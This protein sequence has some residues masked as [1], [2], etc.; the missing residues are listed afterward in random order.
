VFDA[1]SPRLVVTDS[2]GRRLI[3]VEKA[4]VTLGRRSDNDVR[5][6][7]AGVSRRHAEIHVGPDGCRIQDCSSRFGTFVNGERRAD[8]VLTHGDRIRLGQSADTDI[9]FFV[10]DADDL[11]SQAKSAV[12]AASE[13]RNLAA[14]L[15]G[16]RALGSGRVL[17]DVLTL[18]LDAA[19][20]VTGAERAFI[21][22]AQA[23][24]R[25]EFMR[26]RGRGRVTLSGQTFATSR[27][28]PDTVFATG[29]P[30]IVEDLLDTGL[31]AAHAGTVAIGIRHVLCT[32]LRLVR[33]VERVDDRTED[34]RI[35]VL[36]LDSRERGALGAASTRS[37][38]ETL[39]T[40]AAIAIENARLYREALERSKLEQELQ[41]A[42]AIQQAL[43]PNGDVTGGFFTIA[44]TSMPCRAIGGDFFDYLDRPGGPFGFMLGDV[45]GKG[46]PAALLAA[47]VLGMFSAEAG[48]HT[49]PGALMTRLNSGLL[50]RH[51]EA[52]FVTAFYGVLAPDGSLTYSNAGHNPPM[53][54]T[55]DGVRRLDTGGLVLGL[56]AHGT[57]DEETL[58]LRPGDAVVVFSDGVTEALDEAGAEFTDERLLAAVMGQRAQEPRAWLDALVADV[59][60]FCGRATPSDD[61]T[62]MVVRYDGRPRGGADS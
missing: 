57:F 23:G 11:P 25:L 47:A 3:P 32:P 39:S 26:G 48:Y 37:A 44:G 55:A 18:V 29:Q 8:H 51:I 59:R 50:R 31:A 27:K 4:V 54:V 45:A 13:L 62:M 15:E 28:I 12:A 14:L 40:E 41:M 52:R 53:L 61:L 16:L 6:T 22:L 7:D 1:A 58:T 10:G 21:M 34:E 2:L 43:L 17:D 30:L 38:L 56:F 46:S 60:A 49:S 33:Y 36:Y 35:G 19:I 5:V 9:V 42:A 24:R 20:D